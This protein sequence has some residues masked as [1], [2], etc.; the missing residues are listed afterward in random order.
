MELSHLNRDKAAAKVGHPIGTGDPD[1]SG[2]V[3][4]LVPDPGGADDVVELGVAG[5]PA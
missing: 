3:A 5:M 1:L 4:F 2:G